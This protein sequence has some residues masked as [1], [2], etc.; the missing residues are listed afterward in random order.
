[1][2][3]TVGQTKQDVGEV[4]GGKLGQVVATE[5][6]ARSAVKGQKTRAIKPL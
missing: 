2:S 3:D 1:M 6:G 4:A 5:K